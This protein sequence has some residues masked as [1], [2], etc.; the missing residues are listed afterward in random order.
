MYEDN[1]TID[2]DM[3]GEIDY[4]KIPD[5]VM[6][7]IKNEDDFGIGQLL[8]DELVDAANE[9]ASDYYTFADYEMAGKTS[10]GK[11]GVLNMYLIDEEETCENY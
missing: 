1:T 8:Y 4:M 11:S 7:Y 2:M 9:S 3:S 6:E 10:S 5:Q